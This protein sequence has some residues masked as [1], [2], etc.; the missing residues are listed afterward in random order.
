MNI[1]RHVAFVIAFAAT[2]LAPACSQSSNIADSYAS[3]CPSPGPSTTCSVAPGGLCVG[4]RPDLGCALN[5]VPTGLPCSG[6]T[7]CSLSIL[8]CPDEV[9][10]WAGG[11]RVDGYVCS[12]INDQWSCDDCWLG[13][14]LCAEE[15][16]GESS[17]PAPLEDAGS[18]IPLDAPIEAASAVL[19]TDLGPLASFDALPPGYS[20]PVN[21]CTDCVKGGT[22]PD[23]GPWG[24]SSR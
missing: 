22:D 24:C 5:A 6:H 1:R 19:C 10:T 20:G 15:P 18:D 12:C 8:P 9:Q 17:V 16:D 4:N 2:G 11:G 21:V 13:E 23:S 3:L 14:A 7:Q